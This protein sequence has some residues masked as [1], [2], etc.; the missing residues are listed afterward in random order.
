MI[1]GDTFAP[2]AI[3]GSTTLF[4]Y[5]GIYR[6]RGQTHS[7]IELW[8]SHNRVLTDSDVGSGRSWI[9]H[10]RLVSWRSRNGVLAF[11][12]ISL[13]LIARLG[14]MALQILRCRSFP[15]SN[16]GRWFAV[17]VGSS[18]LRMTHHRPIPAL[19]KPPPPLRFAPF[20][21]RPVSATPPPQPPSQSPPRP[22]ATASADAGGAAVQCSPQRAACNPIAPTDRV[23]LRPR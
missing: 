21:H 16:S 23:A 1:A 20:S 17:H 15:L 11:A 5:S 9:T 8:T 18:S 14:L 2:F 6:T 13:K 10:V 22:T 4:L 19:R 3:A 12:A 7:S